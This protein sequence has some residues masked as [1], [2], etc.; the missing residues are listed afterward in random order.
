MVR[1]I[2]FDGESYVVNIHFTN[3]A[4]ERM[5]DRCVARERI[6]RCI[7]RGF[8]Y[9]LDDAEINLSCEPPIYTRLIHSRENF[10]IVLL[11]CWNGWRTELNVL[12]ITIMLDLF[13]P[14]RNIRKHKHT[15]NH[16][17]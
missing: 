2:N 17:V 15:K 10:K 3:H 16:T 14:N 5:T 8:G 12:V 9:V 4:L 6:I 1:T 11:S 13:N 7:E